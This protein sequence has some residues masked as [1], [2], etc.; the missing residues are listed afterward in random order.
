M[1]LF[2]NIECEKMKHGFKFVSDTP[3]ASVETNDT[4]KCAKS[5]AVKTSCVAWNHEGTVCSLLGNYSNFLQTDGVVSGRHH[6]C[7][8]KNLSTS[9]K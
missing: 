1:M 3:M 7:L 9:F 5:C 6:T 8:S 2:F 4:M